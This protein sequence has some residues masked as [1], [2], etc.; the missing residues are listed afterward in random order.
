MREILNNKE[1][2]A[3]ARHHASARAMAK[4]ARAA[5]ISRIRLDFILS[6]RI[7]DHLTG[8]SFN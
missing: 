3:L 6:I 1:Q 8:K 5:L 2:I 4:A 7:L